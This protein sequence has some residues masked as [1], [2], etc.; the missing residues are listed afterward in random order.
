MI[1]CTTFAGRKVAVFGLGLS[2]L[3]SVEALLAGGADVAAWDDGASGRGAALAAGLTLTDLNHADWRN[4]S[5]LVL[6]PGV[7]LTHPEPHWTVR[8]ARD[9]GVAIIGDTELFFRERA[10]HCPGAPVVAI[11]GTNGK[12]TTT[13][14]TAHI[15]RA[16]GTNS[17]SGT[18]S[19]S[20][21]GTK[22]A[23]GGNIGKAVLSLAPLCD[24]QIYVLELSSYQL[25]LTP[26]IHC[27]AAA[28]LNLSPDHLDRHGDMD[29]YAAIKALIFS[30]MGAS[31]T[32]VIGVDDNRSRA[33]FDSLR[34]AENGAGVKV[35]VSV[36][37]KL[38]N[39]IYAADNRLFEARDGA[40]RE[41][42]SLA[43]IQSLRGTHNWQNA[44]VAIA[45]ARGVGKTSRELAA[46]L[47]SFPGL[48]HRMEIL[49]TRDRV[50]FVNDSKG[51]NA[52]A[53][54]KALGAFNDIYWIA[55]GRSKEGGIEPLRPYFSRI[56]KAYLI[57]EATADFAK[58][59]TGAVEFEICGTLDRAIECAARDAASSRAAEPV[60]M[61]SPACASF[62]QYRSFELRG[63]HF[64]Q[65]VSALP[66]ISLNPRGET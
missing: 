2:G 14:L 56:A 25:D 12:S 43:G 8:R 37:G 53:A 16:S 58:T 60:V 29:R 35:A 6:A 5:A 11:T 7:P 41:L 17:T 33:I 55:G 23:M 51:T 57:G 30:K 28:L 24:D 15:L 62:D 31:D 34:S 47:R 63:N 26:S 40:A 48:A 3:A 32:A 1:R 10:A 9:A 21:T 13:A 61:L 27:N 54:Q 36:L 45:L 19:T 65:Q 42:V 52:D 44:A 49:G 64:R 46:G 4:F 39:G 22:V 20:R 38:A 59:L 66:D 50:L 18:S